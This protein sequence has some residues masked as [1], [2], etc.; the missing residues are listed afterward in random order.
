MS[1]STTTE[2]DQLGTVIE[3]FAQIHALLFMQIAGREESDA[4][5][6]ILDQFKAA[7]RHRRG[8]PKIA[9]QPFDATAHA[10][11]TLQEVMK[12]PPPADGVGRH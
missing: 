6:E 11:R 4:A 3:A 9:V 10:I 1:K 2:A 12:M 5:L 8:T 7:R